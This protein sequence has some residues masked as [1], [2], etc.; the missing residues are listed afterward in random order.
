MAENKHRTKTLM[1][2]I[3][4]NKAMA[5]SVQVSGIESRA[6]NCDLETSDYKEEKVNPCYG[7]FPCAADDISRL[8]GAVSPLLENMAL[9][10]RLSARL[11]LGN[12]HASIGSKY[13]P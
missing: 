7:T 13:F 4:W 8:L 6:I 12:S 10:K 1:Y 11:K 2:K 3:E 9:Y 5:A